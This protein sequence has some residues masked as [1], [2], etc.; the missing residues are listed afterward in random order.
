MQTAQLDVATKDDLKEEL[1]KIKTKARKQ[2]EESKQKSQKIIES[3][4]TVG[5]A[6]FLSD[7]LGKIEKEVKKANPGFD[8]LSVEDQN[9]KLLEKQGV[10]GFDIDLVA[11]IAGVAV[12]FTEMAGSYSDMA[13]SFGLGALSAY[14]ARRMYQTAANAPDEVEE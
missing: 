7:Y 5:T 2:A 10:A 9:K 13:N 8:T 4:V 6:A 14:A 11:G 3:A 12:G 1:L